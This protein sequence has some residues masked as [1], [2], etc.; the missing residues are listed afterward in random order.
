MAEHTDLEAI[1]EEWRPIDGWPHE[2]SS[3]GRVRRVRAPHGRTRPGLLKT[4]RWGSYVHVGLRD[5]DRKWSAI[6]HRIV[7]TAFIPNPDSK[8]EVN[9]INGDGTDTPTR[10][11]VRGQ[12]RGPRR[13]QPSWR[14][15]T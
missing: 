14:R 8:P 11:W 12:R 6:V 13:N 10:H 7:A 5:G 3:L 2:V 4:H 15:R 1:C 9:H